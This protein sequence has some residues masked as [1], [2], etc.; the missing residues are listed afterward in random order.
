ML[1]E[2]MCLKFKSHKS[3]KKRFK[4]QFIFIHKSIKFSTQN[5]KSFK[6]RHLA[7]KKQNHFPFAANSNC[8]YQSSPYFLVSADSRKT[9]KGTFN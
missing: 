9:Y 4:M 6:V 2:I 3:F 8:L 7:I 1:K 5:R